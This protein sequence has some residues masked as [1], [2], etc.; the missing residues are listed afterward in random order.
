MDAAVALYASYLGSLIDVSL[1]CWCVAAFFDLF[2]LPD[3]CISR[4]D[5]S[6]LI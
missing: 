4:P 5:E 2:P 1:L 3:E 6:N